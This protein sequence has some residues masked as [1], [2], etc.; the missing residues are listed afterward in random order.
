MDNNA[1]IKPQEILTNL[2]SLDTSA[3]LFQ[4]INTDFKIK[5]AQ[6]NF[7]R[8]I[9]KFYPNNFYTTSNTSIPAP[10]STWL[11]SGTMSALLH[12][13]T[14]AK[15]SSG[16]DYPLG[17]WSW[18]TM[19]GSQDRI[20]TLVSAYRVNPGR[21]SMGAC[22]TF[23]QQYHLMLQQNI[24]TP[25]PRRQTIL[26]LQEFLQTKI[27]QRE[28][29]ILSIDANETMLQHQTDPSSIY[30]MTKQLGLINLA[31]TIPT[32]QESHTG[33]RLID[34]CL[35]TPN[36]TSALESFG[37]LPYSQITTTD[38]RMYFLDL[39]VTKLFNR[40]PDSPISYPTRLLRTH[41]PKRTQTYVE[42]VKKTL[43]KC[44]YFKQQKIYNNQHISRENGLLN[45]KISMNK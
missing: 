29:I 10:S 43:K 11:P 36:I 12:T 44:A 24:D 33:G 8:T 21:A 27:D 13:W 5:K 17:R 45:Y 6:D 15:I 30:S 9:K 19:Q 16:R 25:D 39:N 3:F 26:D 20:I 1:Q 41:L 28:E 7:D 22:S 32:P 31:D 38:H 2:H 42:F 37:Y 18:I 4:E 23:K 35:V 34:F 14:G 40:K